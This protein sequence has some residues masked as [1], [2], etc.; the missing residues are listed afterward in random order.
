[1]K[2][3]Y[4]IDDI[5]PLTMDLSSEFQSLLDSISYIERLSRYKS[6]S[7]E[8]IINNPALPTNGTREKNAQRC[9]LGPDGKMVNF[10]QYYLGY[11]SETT[12]FLGDFY[13]TRS[14]QNKGCGQSILRLYEELWIS[15]GFSTAILNVDIKNWVAVRFWF[16]NGYSR[17]VQWIGDK[18]YSAD[19]FA[20]LRLEKEL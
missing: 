17:I 10:T 3:Q 9:I 11:K 20:M 8:E 15:A 18:E 1:M 2:K 16:R 4:T 5:I 12:V 13:I 7:A 6:E 14:H 19:T